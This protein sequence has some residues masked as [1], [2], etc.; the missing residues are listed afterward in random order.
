MARK[1]G[2]NRAGTGKIESSSTNQN[3]EKWAGAVANQLDTKQKVKD[4]TV[5]TIPVN[6][7]KTDA[8]NPRKLTID[9]TLLNNIVEQQ[10][11]KDFIAKEENNDWV[12]TYVNKVVEAFGLEGKQVGDFLSLVEFAASLKSASRL[13]HPIV[14]WREES[15]FH[16]IAGERR[17]LSHIL[18]GESHISAKIEEQKPQR[19]DID[20]LQ[21]EENIHRE[22]MTLFEK[23]SRVQKLIE[24]SI[25]LDKVSVTKLSKLIGRSRAESQRYLAVIRYE[26]SIIFEAIEQGKITD[27]K[28]A[29]ALAQLPLEEVSAKLSGENKQKAKTAPSIKV[30]RSANQQVVKKLIE[31][32]AKQLNAEQELDEL[33]LQKSKDINL[34]FNKL[35]AFLEQQEQ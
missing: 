5:K 8:D 11:A 33:D 13:L 35:I 26:S 3:T 2:L 1:L 30:A 25:G 20:T 22:D 4:L 12:E 31:A 27:L 17:L 6:Y 29:A 23:I 24:S 16:L 34:A 14:V 19:A 32:A 18:I 7:V 15:T 21:W 9:I 10:P 28:N